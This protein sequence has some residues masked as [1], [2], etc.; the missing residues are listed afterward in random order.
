MGYCGR[1]GIGSLGLG[2]LI[3]SGLLGRLRHLRLELL[4]LGDDGVA[5]ISPALN[6]NLETLEI[7]N[8]YCKEDGACALSRSPCMPSLSRLDHSHSQFTEDGI[9]GAMRESSLWNSLRTLTL[10]DCRLGNEEVRELTR[11]P[12]APRLRSLGL[13]YNSI[14]PSGTKSLADWQPLRGVWKID[15]HDNLIGDDGLVAILES[16]NLSRLLELDLEQDCWNSR[17]FSFRDEASSKFANSPVLRRLDCIFSGCVDEYHGAAYSPGLTKESIKRIRALDWIRPALWA[18]LSDFSQIDEYHDSGEFDESKELDDHDFRGSPFQLNEREAGQ[19]PQR[20]Q[21]IRSPEHKSKDTSRSEPKISEFGTLDFEIKDEIEGI[22]NLDP[23]PVVDHHLSL[24]LP[25]EDDDRPLPEQAGKIAA[26]TIRSIFHDCEMGTFDVGGGSSRIDDHG[27]TI[28]TDTRFHVAIAGNPFPAIEVIRDTFWWLGVSQR[29]SL[30]EFELTLDRAPESV[31]TKLIQFV[32]PKVL[33][34][35]S[36]YRVDRKPFTIDQFDE[37]DNLIMEIEGA[38]TV[39][40]WMKFS[41]A[42]AG[43]A[44]IYTKHFDG[45]KELFELNMIVETLSYEMTSI[46]FQIMRSLGVVIFPMMIACRD[47]AVD[48]FNCEWPKVEMVGSIDELH[49]ILSAGPYKWWNR[50]ASSV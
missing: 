33:R 38:K 27:E 31:T 14:G 6:P 49:E 30:T 18:S 25:L 34:W 4:P 10:N 3:S 46:V 15:L 20:M 9:R 21:Q 39:D 28:P 35:P 1:E 43:C 23:I 24:S 16:K 42:N 5:A 13:A 26:D 45:V 8:V 11:V 40:G 19:E 29:A 2:S 47:A 44:R 32:K 48:S 36:G 37:F 41:T 12:D 50:G 7:I 17:T 22:E